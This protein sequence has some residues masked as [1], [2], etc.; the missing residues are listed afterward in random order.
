MRYRRVRKSGT[1]RLSQTLARLKCRQRFGRLM[2][3]DKGYPSRLK[4][5]PMVGWGTTRG[6]DDPGSARHL[7]N[8]SCSRYSG[9]RLGV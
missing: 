4:A 8:R 9:L 6:G 5:R 3:G 7:L 1:F 2:L